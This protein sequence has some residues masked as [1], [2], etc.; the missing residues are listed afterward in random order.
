MIIR[1]IFDIQRDI[2]KSEGYSE[3]GRVFDIQ[4][5]IRKSEWFSGCET[6]RLMPRQTGEAGAC[7]SGES[8]EAAERMAL[9]AMGAH[10]CGHTQKNGRIAFS[11]ILP[12][13]D[14]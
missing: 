3:F 7:G 11:E 9:S 1:G 10:V 8:C 13:L 14:R 2:R 12:F 6:A 5:G 4:S